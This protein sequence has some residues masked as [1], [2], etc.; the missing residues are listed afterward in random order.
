MEQG[1]FPTATS[2]STDPSI[3]QQWANTYAEQARKPAHLMKGKATPESVM[4]LLPKRMTHG[5]EEEL[6]INPMLMKELELSAKVIPPSGP[7]PLSVAAPDPIL[8]T[9]MQAVHAGLPAP[10][11]AEALMQALSEAAKPP[12]R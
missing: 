10:T 8:N 3:A 7:Y 11:P 1:V 2:F 9:I 6:V 12:V 5:H 4:G